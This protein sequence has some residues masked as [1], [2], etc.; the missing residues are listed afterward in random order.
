MAAPHDTIIDR[1]D[2]SRMTGAERGSG[3][4][5]FNVLN[6]VF[7]AF[8]AAVMIIPFINVVAVAFSSNLT[9]LDAGIKLWPSEW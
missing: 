9:S 3:D 1:S 5:S 6:V 8:L 2:V 7:M 4:R